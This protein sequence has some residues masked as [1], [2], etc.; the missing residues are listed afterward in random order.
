MR[1][2]L[3]EEMG[4]DGPL[5]A[6]RIRHIAIEHISVRL[7]EQYTVC[8]EGVSVPGACPLSCPCGLDSF[9]TSEAVNCMEENLF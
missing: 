3:Y 8:M 2:I 5:V 1:E 6:C 7:C 4:V 9:G